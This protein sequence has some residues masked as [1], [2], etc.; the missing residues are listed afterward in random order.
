M[1]I[2]VFQ[3]GGRLFCPSSLGLLTLIPTGEIQDGSTILLWRVMLLVLGSFRFRR[4]VV[5]RRFFSQPLS[6]SAHRRFIPSTVVEIEGRPSSKPTHA[7]MTPNVII[8]VVEPSLVVKE[9][10]IML[11]H[12]TE[13]LYSLN[14]NCHICMTEF[15]DG[16]CYNVRNTFFVI[17]KHITITH[18]LLKRCNTAAKSRN[19]QLTKNS[20]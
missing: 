2:I 12:T 20:H 13:T 15:K 10:S 4:R 8:T 1:L 3:I 16:F 11:I 6:F 9:N 19:V 7:Q 18:G 17:Y 5:L 14:R